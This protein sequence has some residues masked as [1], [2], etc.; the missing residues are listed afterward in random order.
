LFVALWNGGDCPEIYA[1]SAMRRRID[2][3]LDGYVHGA[4]MNRRSLQSVCA[5]HAFTANFTAS[6]RRNPH[7][8]LGS[9]PADLIPT[10]AHPYSGRTATPA[11]TASIFNVIPEKK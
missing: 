3:C 7:W 5:C 4:D 11:P 10:S 2:G 1:G 6:F 8:S 9:S